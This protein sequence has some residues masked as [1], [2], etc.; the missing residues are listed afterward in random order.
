[1]IWQEQRW[2]EDID[3][4]IRRYGIDVARE[5]LRQAAECDDKGDRQAATK[6]ASQTESL[7]RNTAMLTMAQALPPLAISGAGLDANPWLLNVQNGTIDLRTGELRPHLR[8]DLITKIAPVIYDPEATSALWE[9][10][11]NESTGGDQEV[12]SF[13]A[14]AVGYSMT[15]LT[16]EERLFFVHGPAASGKSTFIETIKAVLGDYA[17]TADFETFLART[18][19]GAPRNDIARLVG[20]RFVASIEVDE[21]KRLAEGLLK[22]ITGGD[23]VTARFMYH[24][25]FEFAPQFTLWLCANHKPTADAEDSAMWRR[26]TVIPFAHEVPPE[27]RDTLLKQTLRDTVISGPAVLAWAVRGCL[28]WQRGGLRIPASVQNA[29]ESYRQEMDP[30]L[31]FIEECCTRSPVAR[32]ISAELTQAYQRWAK[33]AGKEAYSGKRLMDKLRNMGCQTGVVIKVNGT[34]R[35][36]V[37]GLGLLGSE[38]GEDGQDEPSPDEPR[39]T[40]RKTKIY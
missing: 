38:S 1:L 10:F 5:R 11:L 27:K 25:A 16:T 13:L 28:D 20:A 12:A 3:Q 6:W 18:F 26:I 39:L 9:R 14:R 37:V 8:S 22:T 36:C 2:Q 17:L 29:T 4:Q 30:L 35:K 33:G 23:T 40:L 34:T 21:G 15:G 32:V 24:E 31:E 7:Q 19:V